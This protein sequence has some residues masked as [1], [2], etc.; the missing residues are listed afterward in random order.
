MNIIAALTSSGKHLHILV[1]TYKPP[2]T[3]LNTLTYLLHSEP[4]TQYTTFLKQRPQKTL[5]YTTTME[6]MALLV[7]LSIL[8]M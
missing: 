3:Y 8:I 2:Q 1:H 5:M 6:Y 4:Q 7:L